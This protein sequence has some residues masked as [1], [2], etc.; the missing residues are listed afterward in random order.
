MDSCLSQ[1]K[2]RIKELAKEQG[3]TRCGFAK[4]EEIDDV[5]KDSY[6]NWLEANKHDEMH[7]MENYQEI[8]N[9]P[10]GLLP[11]ARTVICFAMNYK[12]AVE[13]PKNMPQFAKYSYGKDYHDVVKKHLRPIEQYITE[14]TGA[15]CRIC[16][17]TA[18]IRE[19][20]W[21]QKAG[22]GFIGKNNQ[23]IIPDKGSYFFLSEIITTAAFESDSPCEE[24]CGNCRLCIDHCPVGALSI[25]G[26]AV[27]A[28]RCLSCQTIE[29]RGELKELT[30]KRLGNRIYGCDECQDVC[31]HNKKSKATTVEE[32]APSQEFME[33]DWEKAEEMNEDDFKRIFK[34]SA[35]KRCKYEGL[36][37]NI[38][39]A[40][41]NL[42]ETTKSKGTCK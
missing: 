38:Q 7:Y 21:A 25:K 8:R 15:E 17:D 27:D 39:A 20:Y 26:G 34:G 5:A 13:K 33:L 28:R 29:H 9:N 2:E 6:C 36:Q 18:P 4:S 14:T 3:F 23:L 1:C 32:L 40:K 35:V 16:V 22:I 11:G 10:D 30:S 19:R 41:S 42:K 37:R 24:S 31:P 12:P